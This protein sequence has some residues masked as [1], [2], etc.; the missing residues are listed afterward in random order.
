VGIDDDGVPDQAS[1]VVIGAGALVLLLRFDET[2][3]GRVDLGM[4]FH[5]RHICQCD[6]GVQCG[7]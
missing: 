3:L 2:L 1:D 7:Q 5:L 4:S 6:I